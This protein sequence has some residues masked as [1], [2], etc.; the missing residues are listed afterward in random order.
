MTMFVP[1]LEN[2]RQKFVIE[3]IAVHPQAASSASSARKL[4]FDVRTTS[5]DVKIILPAGEAALLM[6]EIGY[7]LEQA[8]Q[9]DADKAEVVH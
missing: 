1:I 4:E 7:A 8:N 9:T 5:G 3:G 6:F 2:T